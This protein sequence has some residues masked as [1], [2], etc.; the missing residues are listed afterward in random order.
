MIILI[1]FPSYDHGSVLYV[2]FWFLILASHFASTYFEMQC[3]CMHL[4]VLI[5]SLSGLEVDGAIVHL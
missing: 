1:Y 3:I 5:S 4:I 2:M